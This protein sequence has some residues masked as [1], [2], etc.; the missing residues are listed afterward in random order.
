MFGHL[1]D[2]EPPA[3]GGGS[4]SEDEGS[5]LSSGEEGSDGGD[6]EADGWSDEEDKQEEEGSGSEE[7]AGGR[8][9][10]RRRQRDELDDLFGQVRI[11]SCVDCESLCTVCACCLYGPRALHASC[12]SACWCLLPTQRLGYCSHELAAALADARPSCRPLWPPA[13]S[14]GQQQRGGGK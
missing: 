8:G 3:R 4:G 2:D 7:E 1:F 10:G 5:L 13:R 9:G 12:C 14:A 11:G 6:E